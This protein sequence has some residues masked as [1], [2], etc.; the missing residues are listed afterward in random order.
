MEAFEFEAIH[1]D[2]MIKI[3]NEL[4]KNLTKKLKII[5]QP[6]EEKQNSLSKLL[7]DAPTWHESDVMDFHKK[8]QEGY[9]NWKIAEF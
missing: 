6:E 1:K 8:I 3:P 7:L 2:G 4:R 9:R 5:I